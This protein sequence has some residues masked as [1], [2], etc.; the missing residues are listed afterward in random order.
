MLNELLNRFLPQFCAYCEKEGSVFCDS[1]VRRISSDGIFE[2][3]VCR[4]N[5]AF[6]FRHEKCKGNLDSIIAVAHYANP[7]VQSLLKVF[8][9]EYI[10]SIGDIIGK[11]MTRFLETHI[12]LIPC[13][14]AIIPITLHKKRF[15]IRGFNQAEIIAKHI[16]AFFEKPI[17][18]DLIFRNRATKRQVDLHGDLR[19]ENVCGAFS[20][21]KKSPK[22]I[23]LIDDVATTCSTLEEAAKVLKSAGCEYASAFVFAKG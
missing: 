12:S 2:C 10:E 1:C 14:D 21:T 9:Y 8:K 20:A 5:S 4:E 17:Y 16:S 18:N 22:R 11:I 15:A 13:F 19:K 3:P 6:G 7:T 23:L